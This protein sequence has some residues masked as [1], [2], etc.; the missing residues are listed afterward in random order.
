MVGEPIWPTRT[1]EEYPACVQHEA[2][3]NHAFQGRRVTIL[4]PYDARLLS[5]DVL[6]DAEATHPILIDDAGER[7][8]DRYAPDDVIV[9]YNTALTPPPADAFTLTIGTRDLRAARR[10][11]AELATQHRLPALRATD[12]AL[13]ATELL[14]NSI[15]HGA[16]NALLRIWMTDA[17]LVCEVAGPSRLTNPLAG[18]IPPRPLQGRGR[19]LLIVNRMADL[20][21]TH[22]S[23]AGTTIRAYFNLPG[24]GQRDGPPGQ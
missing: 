21:R 9:R 22:S 17:T 24:Q 2:L 8:S 7:L 15:E 12:L 6:S 4:C 20:V 11:V 14:T 19:G 1:A 16:G 5:V 18:R 10:W 23:N 3:I 13:V